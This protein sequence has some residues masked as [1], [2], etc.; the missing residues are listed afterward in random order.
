V[1]FSILFTVI[2]GFS[3]TIVEEH[4]YLCTGVL[5]LR[6]VVTQAFGTGATAETCRASILI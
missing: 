1:N 6:R 2:I 5:L 4:N 3:G